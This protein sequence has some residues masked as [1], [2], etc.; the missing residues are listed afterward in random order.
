MSCS[1]RSCWR[2]EHAAK[3]MVVLGTGVVVSRYHRLKVSGVVFS[4][5]NQHKPQ[6]QVTHLFSL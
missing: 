5:G 6:Q 1:G 3:A 2:K 4:G